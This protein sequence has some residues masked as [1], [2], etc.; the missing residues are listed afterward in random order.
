VI[1]LYR[2]G[3]APFHTNLLMK[4]NLPLYRLYR[5]VDLRAKS[6][7]G[8]VVA[9]YAREMT[10][11]RIGFYRFIVLHRALGRRETGFAPPLAV[12]QPPPRS[13]REL[14]PPV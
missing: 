1:A 14:V 7:A 10:L 2:A 8:F 12:L 13:A 11:L 4:F 3:V 6:A 5:G 9:D